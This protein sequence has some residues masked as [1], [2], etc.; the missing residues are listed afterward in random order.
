MRRNGFKTT[1]IAAAL[2]LM[3]TAG[4]GFAQ[5]APPAVNAAGTE[6]EAAPAAS[7]PSP[8]LDWRYRVFDFWVGDW[9]VFDHNGNYAGRNLISIEEGGCLVLERWVSVNGGTGQSYNYYN[10]ASDGWRQIWVSQSLTI[11]YE[12]GY[13][14]D[15]GMALE[16]EITYRNGARFPFRGQWT[17]NRNGTVTQLFEQFD[18][19][20]GAWTPWFIGIYRR[21][22]DNPEADPGETGD[23]S[24]G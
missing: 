1:L 23:A 18:P 11:D 17:P 20:T 10:P 7:Q 2:A 5:D 16:G 9:D 3:P 4:T 22:E 24:G 14:E 15:G 19:E 12:G 8:C 21:V 13:A 6:S